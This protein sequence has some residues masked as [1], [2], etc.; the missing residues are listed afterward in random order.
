LHSDSPV[1]DVNAGHP[2][3]RVRRDVNI[4]LLAQPAVNDLDFLRLSY[5]LAESNRIQQ[6]K[7]A[8]IAPCTS[9]ATTDDGNDDGDY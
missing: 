7:L 5:I 6:L 9:M 3:D 1:A 8:T 4:F 2:A